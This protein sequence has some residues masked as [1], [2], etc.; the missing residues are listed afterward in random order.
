MHIEDRVEALEKQVAELKDHLSPPAIV[1]SKVSPAESEIPEHWL[2]DDSG[3]EQPKEDE[4]KRYRVVACDLH[5]DNYASQLGTHAV[6]KAS[7]YDR[8]KAENMKLADENRQLILK[9]ENFRSAH[10]KWC[11]EGDKMRACLRE[12]GSDGSIYG[13]TFQEAIDVL[14]H[15][16]KTIN[17][18]K[19][20]L[21]EA[22]QAA[23]TLRTERDDLAAR[24]KLLQAERDVLREFVQAC[25]L[26]PAIGIGPWDDSH[27]CGPACSWMT[28]ATHCLKLADAVRGGETK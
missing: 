11:F 15:W 21:A 22:R 5:G 3:S 27:G 9:N 28:S 18:L 1:E 14:R 10:S 25:T 23:E 4:P 16:R 6:V 26:P 12:I 7:A 17:K 13:S 19:A 8:L 24:N 20:D 2:K